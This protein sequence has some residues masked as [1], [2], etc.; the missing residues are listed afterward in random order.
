MKTSRTIAAALA[1]LFVVGVLAISV[2]AAPGTQK[3]QEPKASGKTQMPKE[4]MAAMQEGLATRQ[5]RQDFPFTFFKQLIL[6]AAQ[7]SLYPIVFF[8]AKNGDLGYAPSAAGTGAMETTINAF[9]GFYQADATGALKPTK[10]GGRSQSILTADGTDYSADKEDWY[11][12]GYALPTGAYTLAMAL[13]TPDM[14]KLSVG[15]IDIALPG[16]ESHTASLWPTDLV[17][18]TAMDQVEPDQRPTIH[19]GYFTWGAAK[20]VANAASEVGSGENLEI[21]FFVLGA[22]PKDPAAPQGLDL[23]VTFEVQDQEGKPA[24]KWAPSSYEIYLVNQPLPLFQT[25]QKMD[26]KGT[27]LSTEKKALP[28]GNYNLTVK[29]LDKVSGKKADTKM[30]FSVK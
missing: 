19:R 14:K 8:K 29:I 12:F 6:P 23:E 15:Y 21:L 2:Q 9:F 26:E 18:V 27:V 16:P 4:I 5:G 1:V 7:D 30:A 13:A 20:V 22:S 10:F 3:Q 11:T 28:A 17:I 25:L 24:I